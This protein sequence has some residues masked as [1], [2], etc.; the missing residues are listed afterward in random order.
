MPRPGKTRGN[1]GVGLRGAREDGPATRNAPGGTPG[2][3]LSQTLDFTGFGW[4]LWD[5][6]NSWS[7]LGM[8]FRLRDSVSRAVPGRQVVGKRCERPLEVFSIPGHGVPGCP[9]SR[10]R[11]SRPHSIQTKSCKI[12]R[13]LAKSCKSCKILQVFRNRFSCY[14]STKFHV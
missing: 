5:F 1:V 13:N 12:L 14:F 3:A 9:G 10:W 2:P 7:G 11:A 6:A 8:G 4:I